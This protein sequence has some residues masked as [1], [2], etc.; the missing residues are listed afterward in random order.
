MIS[1]WS[2]YFSSN[3]IQKRSVQNK[4]LQD[5]GIEFDFKITFLTFNNHYFLTLKHEQGIDT[6]GQKT[7]LQFLAVFLDTDNKLIKFFIKF[8]V[9]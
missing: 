3:I 2:L 6:F 5:A 9:K 1:F 8:L 7:C 4:T